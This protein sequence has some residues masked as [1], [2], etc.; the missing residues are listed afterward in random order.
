[1][2]TVLKRTA[3]LAGTLAVFSSA[4]ADGLYLGVPGYGGNGCPVGS[5]SVTLS[6]DQKSLSILFD[7]YM[8]EAG[9]PNGRQVDRKTC[10]ISIPVHVPQGLSVSIFTV[11]YRG[12]NS[13]PSGGRSLFSTEYFFAGV[14]GPKFQKTFQ[15]PMEQDYTLTSSLVGVGQVWSACG[16]DVN[17]RVNTSMT[18]YTNRYKDDALSTVD[19]VDLKSGLV[20]HL[21]WKSCGGNHSQ[22]TPPQG[23]GR[24]DDGYDNGGGWDQPAPAPSR[25]N[26]RGGS[27]RGRR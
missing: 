25:G 20:Y 5:A 13:L 19:S 1:M 4:H 8:A 16:E 14:R 21:Q 7:Q 6:P 18:A 27:R 22:P 23:S 15:G 10:N 24:R 12:F 9:G 2:K 26:S 3:L 17:L 11:D